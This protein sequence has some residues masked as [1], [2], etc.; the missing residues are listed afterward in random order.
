MQKKMD[1]V[2]FSRF[3][4]ICTSLLGAASASLKTDVVK[5]R[6]SDMSVYNVSDP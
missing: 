3:Y 1:L 4:E 2:G 6:Q 5:T